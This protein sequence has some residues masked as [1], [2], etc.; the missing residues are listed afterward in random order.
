M[1]AK[2]LAGLALLVLAG[3]IVIRFWVNWLMSQ[4]GPK[5]R[6][7]DTR[8]SWRNQGRIRK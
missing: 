8:K 3:F 1:D 7:P 2:T 5:I 6:V 4:P